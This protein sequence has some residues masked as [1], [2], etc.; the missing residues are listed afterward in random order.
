MG[1]I[2]DTVIRL[3]AIELQISEAEVRQA[4]S[5]RTDLGMDSIA[6]A[7]LMFALEE[8]Y[9]VEISLDQVERLDTLP[10]IEAVVNRSL[11]S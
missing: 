11:V 6:A 7:N 10:E 1:D 5:L 4:Q 8:E 9:G 2:A 3:I